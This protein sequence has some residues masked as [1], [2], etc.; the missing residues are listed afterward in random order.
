M[1]TY[2]RSV[3]FGEKLGSAGR[4]DHFLL[5]ISEAFGEGKEIGSSVETV[6]LCE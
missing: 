6:C 5:N 1:L 2:P 4:P 3:R